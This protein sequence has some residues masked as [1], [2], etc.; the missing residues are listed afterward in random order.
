MLTNMNKGQ[1]M[2]YKKNLSRY[3]GVRLPADEF[4]QLVARRKG[5]ESMSDM[6]RKAVK[7]Y[8]QNS[9]NNFTTKSSN[10]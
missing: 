7:H 3:V 6:V 8:L 5:M 4:E 1:K 2:V 10:T 9:L